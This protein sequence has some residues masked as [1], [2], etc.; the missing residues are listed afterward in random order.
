M[1]YTKWQFLRVWK[2]YENRLFVKYTNFC[3]R[4][5]LPQQYWSTLLK[6]WHYQQNF[7][8]EGKIDKEWLFQVTCRSPEK[9]V[10]ILLGYFVYH[11]M[12]NWYCAATQNGVLYFLWMVNNIAHEWKGRATI[13]IQ[14]R[15]TACCLLMYPFIF[16]IY[17][18][19]IFLEMAGSNNSCNE[20]VILCIFVFSSQKCFETT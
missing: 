12:D 14:G 10:F 8:N 18:F 19:L 13:G 5:C 3:R 15:N 11:F 6:K 2:L 17:Y 9:G 4:Q 16:Y 7:G 1:V 20:E